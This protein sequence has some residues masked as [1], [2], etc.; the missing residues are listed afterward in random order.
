VREKYY[1]FAK[2]VYIYKVQ[3]NRASHQSRRNPPDKEIL[4]QSSNKLKYENSVNGELSY[5]FYE[6]K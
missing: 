3:V 2:T 1:Y 5:K 4:H 6:M